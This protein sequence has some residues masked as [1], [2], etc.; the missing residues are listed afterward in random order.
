MIINE[1]KRNQL[2]AKSKNSSN[3]GIQRFKRRLKSRVATSTQQYNRLDMNQLFKDDI[4]S[5]SIEVNGEVTP[6]NIEVPVN[7]YE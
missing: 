1:D 7:P 3:G 6:I 4:L 2:V 5:I